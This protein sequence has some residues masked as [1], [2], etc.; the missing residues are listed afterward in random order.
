MKKRRSGYYMGSYSV[1]SAKGAAL[2]RTRVGAKQIA[3]VATKCRGCGTV[4]VYLNGVLLK[5]VSLARSSIARKQVIPVATFPS[6]RRGTVKVVVLSSGKPVLIE[7]LG[8]SAF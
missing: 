3:L 2:V 1:A 8:T 7:G 6:L 5:K 4:G